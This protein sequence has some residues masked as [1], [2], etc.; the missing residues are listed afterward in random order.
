MV[1][2]FRQPTPD[3]LL[4]ISEFWP[5][6]SRLVKQ[7]FTQTEKMLIKIGYDIAVR[8]PIPTAVIHLLHVHPTRRSDLVEPEHFSTEPVLPL[9]EYYD[10]FGNRRGRLRAPA[11]TLRLLS[12]TVIRDSGAPDPY[13]PNVAQLDI[14]ELPPAALQFLLPSRY[15]EVDSELMDFAWRTF[16]ATRPGW[17]R[18]QAICDFV[19]SHLRFDYQQARADRTAREALESK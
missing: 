6:S 4:Q 2:E 17:E 12:E 1:D 3:Y 14:S 15:C 8:F 16:S 10:S 13:A 19:H 7:T 5:S 18:V 11:G 9:E